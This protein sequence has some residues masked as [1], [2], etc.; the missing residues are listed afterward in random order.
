MLKWLKK[1]KPI[2]L[3]RWAIKEQHIK[4]KIDL[5]NCDSCGVCPPLQKPITLKY[6]Y[7][8]VG[9]DIIFETVEGTRSIK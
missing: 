1:T 3:G 9:D 6:K 2:S 8:I 7:M 4:R 5:A